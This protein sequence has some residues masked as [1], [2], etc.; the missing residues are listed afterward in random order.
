MQKCTNA[1]MRTGALATVTSG[2]PRVL[3][4]F[5]ICAFLHFSVAAASAQAPPPTTPQTTQTQEP[6]RFR[7][8]V[9]LTSLD[10]TVVDDRGK[11]VAGLAPEDFNVRIDGG[12]RRVVSA[13]W[14]PLAAA[15]GA[16]PPPPPPDGFSTNE[17]ATGGRLIVLA[18]D[19]PNIRFGGA[20]AIGRAANAF[21]DRLGP[22]D[23]VAVAGI[24]TGAPSTP[25]TSDRQRIKQAISRL[26]GRKHPG[27][28]SIDLGH[29]IGLAEAMRVDRGDLSLLETIQERECAGIFGP[30]LISCR[31]EVEVEVRQKA[32]DAN[33]EGQETIA[34]LRSILF[35]LRSIEGAKTLVFVSEGFVLT[36]PGFVT[37]LG[38]LAAAARTSLYVLRLDNTWFDASIARMPLDPFSDRRAQTEALDLLTGAARGALF[39]VVGNPQGLFDR[40]EAEL[41]GYYLIGVESD[42]KDRDGKAHPIRVDVPRK[43]AIVRSRRQMINTPADRKLTLNRRQTAGAALSSPLV[44]SG[45]PLRVGSFAL[46]GP[47]RDRVQILIHADI[48]NEYASSKVATIAYVISDAN[49][50][51]I[52]NTVLDARLPPVVSGVPSALQYKAGASLAPGDYTLKLAAVEGD[53]VG[54]VEH[55]IHAALPKS[56][57]MTFSELMVGGPLTVGELLQPTI[58]YQ[59][60]FGAV[61]GY[62]ET[63][64][65]S[66]SD[67]SVEYEIGTDETSPALLNADVSPY[68]AGEERTIFTRVI[69]VQQLPPG[70]YVLRAI[71]SVNNR[72]VKTLARGFEIAKPKVLMT[73]ADGLGS[74][75]AGDTELF[76][77]VDE[78]AIR[79]AFPKQDAVE[80]ETLAPFRERTP[81]EVKDAFDQGVAFLTAAEYPK[82][83]AS[84]KRA[85]QPE[86]DSTP[87]LAYLAV[88]FAAAGHDQQA[89]SAFQTA[90]VDGDDMPQIYD[91]LG[92][93]LMRN[94]DF[95]AARAT[96]E[97]ASGK[98]P[99]DVRFA[100]PLAMLYAMFGRGRQAVRTLERYLNDRTD[101]R[102]AYYVAV[103]WLYTLH[104]TGVVVH[105]RT[106]DVQLARKYADAYEQASGPQTPLVKQW[107]GYLEGER[108]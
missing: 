23:K 96:F 45:L 32:I 25:F 53:R 35:A 66:S 84:F 77:P 16:P 55:V 44:V 75:E 38:S 28:S 42:P 68:Q 18:V 79:P 56:D 67:I 61:H 83:E 85:I 17:H 86:I 31:M 101:D 20:M 73:A 100:K 62:F 87:A 2:S 19:E 22:S 41:S 71:V 27:T 98:W 9:E 5:C 6:P 24:G 40:L 102:D 50:K 76:L 29:N 36:E 82:A 78:Q 26:A 39:D 88:S 3:L 43:G 81:A 37:E 60:T 72:S 99:A 1:G 104:S 103:Q 107:V 11:P 95:A 47:E 65:K 12:Q 4:H 106:Q 13:E 91:W 94:H 108:R 90:L 21:V 64:G 89:A 33:T 14:V 69:P 97:E 63:Y 58:G 74:S 10:V 34:G 54:T 80:P 52:T 8:G 93:T 59:V 15:A 49:G 46:Q 70:K 105:N 30:Q 57:A 7:A 92:G 51:V 48:G